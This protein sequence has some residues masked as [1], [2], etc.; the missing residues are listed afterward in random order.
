MLKF[1]TVT[2]RE[3]VALLRDGRFDRLLGPGRHALWSLPAWLSSEL[4][5]LVT[6]EKTGGGYVSVVVRG[7]VAACKASTDA[8]QIAAS[9]I[10]E[11][12]AVHVIARPHVNVDAAMPLGRPDAAKKK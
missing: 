2:R 9:R 11:V 10:G 4:V 7:D 12:T 6:Y 8:G 3:R 5:E 1:I